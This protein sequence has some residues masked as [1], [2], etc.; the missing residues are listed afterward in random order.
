[1]IE[2]GGISF[3]AEARLRHLVPGLR[4]EVQRVLGRE[5]LVAY[6]LGLG[7]DAC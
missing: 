6:N 1:M 4:I 2:A 3:V 7:A 5:G